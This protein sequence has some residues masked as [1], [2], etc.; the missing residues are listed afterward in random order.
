[1]EFSNV[2]IIK[3]WAQK[4]NRTLALSLSCHLRIFFIG[5]CERL[6]HGEQC[7]GTTSTVIKNIMLSVPNSMPIYTYAKRIKWKFLRV[8][9]AQKAEII[10]IW[11]RLFHIQQGRS[12]FALIPTGWAVYIQVQPVVLF[13]ILQADRFLTAEFYNWLRKSSP[14]KFW[15]IQFVQAHWKVHKKNSQHHRI[16]G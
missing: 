16:S 9:G 8:E 2:C 4:S 3:N 13:S 5:H 1:M 14:E 12:M 15:P 6:S 7:T 11:M 10:D